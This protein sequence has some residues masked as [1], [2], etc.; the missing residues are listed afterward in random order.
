LMA[1]RTNLGR[2]ALTI[3]SHQGRSN[4]LKMLLLLRKKLCPQTKFA[5]ILKL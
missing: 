3:K 2:A 1:I 4:L 5:A